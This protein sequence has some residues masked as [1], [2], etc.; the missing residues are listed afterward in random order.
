MVGGEEEKIEEEEEESAGEREGGENIF[1]L[2][3]GKKAGVEFYWVI[4]A[5]RQVPRQICSI[6][7]SSAQHLHT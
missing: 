4:I 1:F 6:T 7:N 2:L 3:G 5:L